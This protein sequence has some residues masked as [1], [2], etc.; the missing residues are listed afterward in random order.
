MTDSPFMT[1]SVDFHSVDFHSVDFHSVDFHGNDQMTGSDPITE[2]SSSAHNSEVQSW[3]GTPKTRVSKSLEKEPA[4]GW[5]TLGR[6]D[7]LSISLKDCMVPLMTSAILLVSLVFSGCSSLLGGGGEDPESLANNSSSYL[8]L[9]ES[10]LDSELAAR[11]GTGSIPEAEGEGL[12]KDVRFGFDSYSV[13][14]IAR[15]RI[16]LNIQ[17]LNA[18]PGVKIQLEGH[19]DERGTTEYNLAL[20]QR[21]AEAVRDAMIALGVDRN[22]I[23]TISYGSEVPLDRASTEVAWAVNRRVHF[24]PFTY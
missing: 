15:E 7:S 18:N 11:Y 22:R 21:R 5:Q 17:V 13:D 10:E 4:Y 24:T 12:F 2:R 1:D 14:D 6:W 16:A 9:S 8:G 20:G 3:L 19:C 23:E